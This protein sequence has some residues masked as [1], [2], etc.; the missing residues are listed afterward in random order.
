MSTEGWGSVKV[1]VTPAVL[2]QK[3]SE[4]TRRIDRVQ[5]LF[6]EM[7][8]RIRGTRA[9]W[10]GA[11]GEAH[12]EAYETEKETVDLILRRLREH[13]D[14]LLKISGLYEREEQDLTGSFRALGD[15]AIT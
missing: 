4:V 14:D 7:D 6:G 8:D 2:R 9:Y 3:A 12:R 5:A 10:I 1:R 13:P 11:G 15:H